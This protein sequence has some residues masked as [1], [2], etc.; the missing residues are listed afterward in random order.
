MLSHPKDTHF[1]VFEAANEELKEIY[2]T[3]TSSAIYE[4]M[5]DFARSL[6]AVV[7]HW[8]PERHH[9]HFRSLEFELSKEQA[10]E[11]I[12]RRMGQLQPV[13]WRLIADAPTRLR[14]A[15]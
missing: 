13:G 2:I 5:A 1:T 10:A 9:I 8:K 15:D 11:Y 7:R 3:S 12:K 6:P 4:A 14:A